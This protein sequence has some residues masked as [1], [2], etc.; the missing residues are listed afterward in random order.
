MIGLL[1]FHWADDYGAMLQAYALKYHLEKASGK[2]VEIIPY[3][4]VKLTGR[5]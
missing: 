2:Q 1:T 3:A 4:P 5:Y